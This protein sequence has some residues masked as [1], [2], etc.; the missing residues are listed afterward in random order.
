MT[1]AGRMGL[2]LAAAALLWAAFFPGLGGLV[3]PALALGFLAVRAAGPK[4][5]LLLGLL[6][7]GAFFLLEFS[8]LRTLYPFIGPMAYGVIV[9]LALYGGLF[10][11]AFGLLAGWKGSLGV[12]AG[13]WTLLEIARGTGPLGFTFGAVPAALAGTPFAAAAGLAGPWLLSLG[14]ALAAAGLAGA[15]RKPH[16]LA[17]ALLSPLV[18]WGLGALVPKPKLVGQVRLALVQPDIPQADRLDR[19]KLPEILAR[20]A[21]LLAQVPAG[22]DLVVIPENATPAF[23]RLERPYLEPFARAAREK[24]VPVM[25]GTADLQG[26]AVRNTMLLLTPDGRESVVYAKIHLVPFGEYVPGRFLFERIGLGALID[27]FL[28]YD[29]S[30][31]ERLE[32]VG[33]YGVVICFESVFPGPTRALARKGAEVLLVSTNDAWFG[34]TRIL[35]EHYA[36]GSLRAAETGRVCLQVGQTGIT[37]AWGPDGRE[38]IRFPWGE[39]VFVLEVPRFAGRTPYLVVGDLPVLGAAG[40][41]LL[42]GLKKGGPRPRTPQP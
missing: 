40:A 38:L 15:R 8:A 9:L 24:G 18:L 36:M 17:L 41:L 26:T 12:L 29:Q 22:V 35:W 21:G 23:L 19:T 10:F 20:Y 3:F 1:L 34:R 14:V 33:I 28:P 25:V 7:G 42:W 13:A 4:R 27:Q 2:A 6:W 16:L 39:G 32:P 11:G 31:G 37:G 30:P 5:G